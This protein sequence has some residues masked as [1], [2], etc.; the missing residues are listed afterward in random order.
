MPAVTYR[1]RISAI[2][3]MG[4]TLREA[5]FLALVALHSGQFLRRQYN[6]F[7]DRKG[8][9]TT[10][11]LIGKL[12]QKGDTSASKL[13]GDQH[14]EGCDRATD[15]PDLEPFLLNYKE[16]GV[17]AGPADVMLG[18][19]AGVQSTYDIVVRIEEADLRHGIRG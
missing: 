9:G 17:V 6:Q 5:G 14:R 16:V 7:L 8:G 10:A 13:F 2:R 15:D 12:L 3:A 19:S 11:P 18:S 4:Y 1:E